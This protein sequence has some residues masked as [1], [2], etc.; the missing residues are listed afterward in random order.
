MSSSFAIITSLSTVYGAVLRTKTGACGFVSAPVWLYT[1]KPCIAFM[2][3]YGSHMTTSICHPILFI[4]LADAL[5][6]LCLPMAGFN[7]A[8]CYIMIMRRSEALGCC[9]HLIEAE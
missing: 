4:I 2:F 8:E 1:L 7:T 9:L 5:S 3:H 6:D